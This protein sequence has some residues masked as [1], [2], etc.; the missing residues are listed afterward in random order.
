MEITTLIGNGRNTQWQ[1]KTSTTVY[2]SSSNFPESG[3]V[4]S[5]VRQLF[6][7]FLMKKKKEKK[8]G[9]TFLKSGRPEQNAE[10][11]KEED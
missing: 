9:K 11:R 6:R 4:G 10:F 2:Q 3:G 7:L 5:P 1:T 8:S